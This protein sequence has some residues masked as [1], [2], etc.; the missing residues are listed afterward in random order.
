MHTATSEILDPPAKPLSALPHVKIR[1]PRDW[2]TLNLVD[3]WRFRDLL[4]ALASRDVKLRYKQT[5]LGIIWVVLQ[6]LMAAGVFSFVFG[7][8]AQLPSHGI[9]YFLFSYVGLLGWNLFSGTLTKTSGCLVGNS[10]LISKIFFPRLV[11]PLSTVPS[12][13]IDFVVALGMMVFLMFLYRVHPHPGL[14][15]LP[16]W[17]AMLLFLSLGVGLVSA[18]L[19]VSYRDVQYIVPVFTQILLYASPVAYELAY[20]LTKIPK[21]HQALYLLNPLAAPLEA[22]RAS[23]LGTPWPPLSSLL[24]AGVVSVAVILIGAYSFKKMERKFA[25]VI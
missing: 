12:V 16:L 3:V 23:L 19:T 24:Y 17:I 20:A 11:L 6:P 21:K 14:L 4:M 7:R 15:L 18:A 8:V 2:A 5:A 13:L 1:P 9:P 10:Q 25:D 22:F